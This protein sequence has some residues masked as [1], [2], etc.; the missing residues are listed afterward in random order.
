MD[1]FFGG[2]G[3]TFF[4][5]GQGPPFDF[6]NVDVQ[7]PQ[8]QQPTNQKPPPASE[9]VV[10]NLSRNVVKITADDLI[11]ATNRECAVCLEEQLLGLLETILLRVICYLILSYTNSWL[12]FY[13]DINVIA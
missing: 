7:V 12:I 1:Y 9:S 6:M 3:P 10:N 4:A 8:Q 13:I 5:G 11:E 2:A